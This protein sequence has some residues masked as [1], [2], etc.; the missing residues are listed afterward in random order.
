M[1]TSIY[2]LGKVVGAELMV[3]GL[4]VCAA[5]YLGLSLLIRANRTKRGI[6]VLL[7]ALLGAEVVC[8]A[9]WFLLYFPGGD[10]HNYGI[11][12]ALG[13]F[14]WPMLL[15][16]AGGIASAVNQSREEE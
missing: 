2:S 7:L 12:G 8:D 13:V 9:V 10:Y 5:L 11:G 15:C 4:L 16:L 3:A 6:R 1:I 14:L